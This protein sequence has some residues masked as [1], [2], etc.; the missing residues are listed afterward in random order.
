MIKSSKAVNAELR[1]TIPAEI[2]RA[3]A[4][5]V[6]LSGVSKASIVRQALAAHLAAMGVVHPSIAETLQPSRTG[7]PG[8]AFHRK[9]QH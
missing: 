6:E 2:D 5:V 8:L 9:E 1:T 4:Q 3:L 7:G